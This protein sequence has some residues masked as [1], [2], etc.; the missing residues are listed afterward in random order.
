MRSNA[1]GEYIYIYIFESS[2][3]QPKEAVLDLLRRCDATSGEAIRGQKGVWYAIES[4]EVGG[5]TRHGKFHRPS[6]EMK[7]ERG[8]SNT[9]K[10]SKGSVGFN[11]E[12]IISLARCASQSSRLQTGFETLRRERGTLHQMPDE[13]KAWCWPERIPPASMIVATHFA[14]QHKTFMCVPQSTDE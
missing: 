14:R 2:Q 1:G 3:R 9:G 12:A 5:E 4:F 8:R 11:A 10:Q 13:M 6:Y 7:P